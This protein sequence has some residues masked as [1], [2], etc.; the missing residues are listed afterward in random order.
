MFLNENY[1]H[2]GIFYP[3]ARTPHIAYPQNVDNLPFFL[4]KPFPY[5]F[6]VNREEKVLKSVQVTERS[7]KSLGPRG[8]KSGPKNWKQWKQNIK[9]V[10]NH[11]AKLIQQG[12]F[13]SCYIAS[14]GSELH[15]KP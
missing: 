11:R 15:K 10:V 3:Q 5:S 2:K 4:V 1:S 13:E 6:I 14:G 7:S 12:D 8:V 9:T